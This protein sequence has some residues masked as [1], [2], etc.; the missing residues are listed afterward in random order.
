MKICMAGI[1][2]TTAGIELRERFAFTPERARQAMAEAS[3][4]DG[5]SGNVLLSTC[6]RTE[7]YLCCEDGV[8]T[9]PVQALCQLAGMDVNQS[10]SLF[11]SKEDADA[12]HYLMEVA[13]GLKSLILGEDQIVSQVRTATEL[14]REAKAA[15]PA[16]ETLFRLAVTAGKEVKTKVQLRAVPGSA[17][18]SAVE[19]LERQLHSLQGRKALV[20]GN[21]EMGRLAASL[22]VE[23]GCNVTV[24][25]RTYRHG[26]TVV[27]RGCRAV[28][29]DDRLYELEK[30]Q[31]VVSA[32]TSPHF[33]LTADML[34]QARTKPEY[35][36]DLAVPRDIDPAIA[37]MDGVRYY[38]IDSFSENGLE[39]IS[40]SSL[41][42][43]RGI[44]DKQMEQFENYLNMKACFPLI[45]DIKK[46]AFDR[47]SDSLA[48]RAE[49]G[50][51]E[52]AFAVNK[53]VDMLLFSI[54]DKLTPDALSAIREKVRGLRS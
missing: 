35:I 13:S 37:D 54:K 36:V 40:H 24:T 1:D 34:A 28:P 51:D 42:Q 53:T 50:E 11:Y 21:G 4:W 5:I 16:L 18:T 26:E 31:I 7:W 14:A 8:Q 41:L 27:P 33:T 20:I 23:K 9:S 43:I 48:A 30:S 45:G 10:E 44:I 52:V 32:T 17:A 49:N 47:I 3:G 15:G 6:N 19:L 29:Y 39:T 25:L 38:N 46:L 2:Y 22:L 12:A